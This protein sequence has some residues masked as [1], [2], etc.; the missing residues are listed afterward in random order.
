MSKRLREIIGYENFKEECKLVNCSYE[1]YGWTG[2]E[3][4]IVF[5]RLTRNEIDRKY[6][7]IAEA[8]SP[9]LLGNY[10]MWSAFVKHK[11]NDRKFAQRAR[12]FET[13]YGFDEL[14]ERIYRTAINDDEERRTVDSIVLREALKSLPESMRNR[15]VLYYFGSLKMNEIAKLEHVSTNA[16]FKSLKSARAR[17]KNVITQ[18]QRPKN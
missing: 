5:S 14:T 16:V 13:S 9:Y 10:D 15:V 1:Y 7:E 2:T 6:P 18:P 12:L 11:S 8:M 17:L 4:Y 3:K